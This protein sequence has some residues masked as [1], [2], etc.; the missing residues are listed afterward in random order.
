MVSPIPA[1]SSDAH[2][3]RRLDRSADQAAGLGNAE[4]QR[5]I[6]RVGKLLIGGDREE[7]VAGLH[8]HLIVAEIMVLED[9]DMVERALD[10]RLRAGL[11]IFFEQ[12]LLEAS[13]IDPDADRAAIGLGRVDDL[14]DP[15]GRAD[16][17]G[18]DPQARRAGVRRLER[19]LVVEVDV[20]DDRDCGRADDLAAAPRCCRRR[21]S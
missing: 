5:A 11:A 17:A 14:A 6:D 20:G 12:I 21:G 16:V 1:H 9:P 4:M 8:R 15:V 7:Q 10:Q 19:A 2:A 3:D 18:I 13:G